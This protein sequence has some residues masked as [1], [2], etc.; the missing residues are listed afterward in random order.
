MQEN[1]S[2]EER[3]VHTKTKIHFHSNHIMYHYIRNQQEKSRKE[4]KTYS[5]PFAHPKTK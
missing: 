4:R 1:K 3:D 5:I 2:R